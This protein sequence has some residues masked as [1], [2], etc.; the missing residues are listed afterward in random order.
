MINAVFIVGE[1]RQVMACEQKDN[2]KGPSALML[3]QYGDARAPTGGAV[4]FVN[5][6]MV[7]VPSFA[8]AKVRDQ[9]QVGS[10]VQINGHLQGVAKVVNGEDQLFTELVSDR[11]TF[12]GAAAAA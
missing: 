12:E 2:S 4:E 3:V 7:R 11:I 1:V 8:Y 5:A 6:A 10:K 9:L